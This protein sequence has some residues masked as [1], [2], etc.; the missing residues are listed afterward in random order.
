MQVADLQFEEKVDAA[1]FFSRS[2]RNVITV[3]GRMHLWQ[4]RWGML[5]TI[6]VA[7]IVCLGLAVAGPVGTTRAG[8]LGIGLGAGGGP[9]PSYWPA[10][11]GIS[12]GQGG[13][14][15]ASAGFR[16]VSPI[17]CHGT[18]YTYRGI[19]RDGLYKIT[20][21]SNSGRIKDVDRIRRWGGG[22]GGYD[23]DYDDGGYGGGGYGGGY[24]G[25]GYGGGG[26]DDYDDEY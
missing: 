6:M 19:R 17:D 13:R 11:R 15:V 24:G 25:G 21:K 16:R 5:K 7:G 4:R 22:G 1:P 26:Y 23:D 18:E 2:S 3:P 10:R 20:L 12:C 9:G 14:I 8:E